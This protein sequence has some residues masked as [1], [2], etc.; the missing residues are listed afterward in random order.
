MN[1]KTLCRSLVVWG[2]LA[3]QLALGASSTPRVKTD[4]GIVEGRADGAVHAFLGIPYAAAPVGDL[5][6]KPPVPGI[7]RCWMLKGRR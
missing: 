5:R 7:T 6:W 1:P 2:M 4:S 3:A